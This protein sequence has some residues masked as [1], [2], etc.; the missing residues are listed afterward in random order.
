ME[1]ARLDARTVSSSLVVSIEGEIDA[2]NASE[3]GGEIE[4][5]LDEA[6]A[7]VIDLSGT[8]YLDSAGIRML[9]EIRAQLEQSGTPLC[10]AVP[11][12]SPTRQVLDLTEVHQVIPVVEDSDDAVR[13]VE[14]G[15]GL[16]RSAEEG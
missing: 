2:S 5:M 8:E 12:E 14:E 13:V 7:L 3:V 15:R 11:A 1:L 6:S 4:A 16:G 9:F 10:I